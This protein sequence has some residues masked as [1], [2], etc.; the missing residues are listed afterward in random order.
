MKV[1]KKEQKRYVV[2]E[3]KTEN[4]IIKTGDYNTHSLTMKRT[5]QKINTK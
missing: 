1:K 3:M 4:S 5:R 2:K